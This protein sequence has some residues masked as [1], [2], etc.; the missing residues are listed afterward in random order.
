MKAIT[1]GGERI[2]CDELEEG[3]NGVVLSYADRIVGYVPYEQLACVAETRT[4]VASS[5]IR[6]IGYDDEEKALEIEFQ[7]GGIYRYA[8]VAHSTY[9]A[10]L[11]ARSHGS[12]FHE[13]VR[14][15]YDYRRVR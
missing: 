8:D 14:G 3:R 11:S 1:L 6:S 13:N 7:S 2:E 4:P 12:Y 10:F 5:S 15:Q 9:E